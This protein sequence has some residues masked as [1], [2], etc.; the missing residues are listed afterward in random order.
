VSV[1]CVCVICLCDVSVLCIV[2]RHVSCEY[3]VCCYES[4]RN[5]AGACAA[6]PDVYSWQWCVCVV[7]LCYVWCVYHVWLVMCLCCVSA[8]CLC[9]CAVCHVWLVM[10]LWCASVLCLCVM[11]KLFVTG[12]VFVLCVCDVCRWYIH[13]LQ[14]CDVS[15]VRCLCRVSVLRWSVVYLSYAM[16]HCHVYVM[17]LDACVDVHQVLS[18]CWSLDKFLF[19]Y[20]HTHTYIYI[21]IFI[22]IHIHILCI[23]TYIYYICVKMCH[24]A[25]DVFVLCVWVLCINCYVYVICHLSRVSHVHC[26][27][28]QQ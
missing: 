26:R 3:C 14:V 22:Y 17:C 27:V 5:S 6:H 18:S 21:Y 9:V 15:L 10:C 19:T 24:P 13:V 16:C 4:R 23:Q 20:I 1:W 28:P 11:R 25:G 2:I 8:L 7:C 12:V